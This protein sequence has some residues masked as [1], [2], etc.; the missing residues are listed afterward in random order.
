MATSVLCQ[1][2][3]PHEALVAEWAGEALLP[4]VGAVVPCQLVGTGKLLGAVR[5]AA[6]EGPLS[7]ETANRYGVMSHHAN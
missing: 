7:L 6:L 2:V 5:P 3:A 4:R 1:V